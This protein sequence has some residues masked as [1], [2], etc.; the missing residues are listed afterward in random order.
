VSSEARLNAARRDCLDSLQPG[1]SP[2]EH[3]VAYYPAW[4]DEEIKEVEV[5]VRRI[6]RQLV[7]DNESGGR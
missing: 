2:I 5:R 7:D 3:L 1:W 6:L 4:T